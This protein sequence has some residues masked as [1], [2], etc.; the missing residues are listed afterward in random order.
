MP[1]DT[2]TI[3][4]ESFCPQKGDVFFW[5]A[6]LAHMGTRTNDPERT[7]RSFVTHYSTTTGCP[8]DRRAADV[9][10]VRLELNGGVMYR[11]PIHPEQEDILV[12][13]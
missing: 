10:P 8:V 2:S 6:C 3:R 5:Y 11:D 4:A 12:R 13:G 9:E 1:V 7:R